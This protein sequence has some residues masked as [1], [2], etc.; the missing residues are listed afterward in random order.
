MEY[1]AQIEKTVDVLS[2]LLSKIPLN[3]DGDG[4]YWTSSLKVFISEL[5]NQQLSIE[6]D[7]LLKNVKED[8][9][10][11]LSTVSEIQHPCDKNTN[12]S[13]IL[14][15]S[16]DTLEDYPQM[17][18]PSKEKE[19]P[20]CTN[21][22]TNT[23]F[24]ETFAEVTMNPEINSDLIFIQENEL[25]QTKTVK[26]KYKRKIQVYHPKFVAELLSQVKSVECEKEEVDQKDIQLKSQKL[27]VKSFK[28]HCCLCKSNFETEEDL[29]NH[30][31]KLHCINETF[32]CDNCNFT[33]ATKKFLIEHCADQHKE[34]KVYKR[35]QIVKGG[36]VGYINRTLKYCRH[37]DQIFSRAVHLRKHLYE[38]H[39][40]TV[41]RN[42]CLMCLR[43]FDKEKSAMHHMDRTHI[44]LKIKCPFLSICDEIFNTD[45]EYQ[46]HFSLKHQKAD[47][48]TCHICGQVFRSNQRA[49][50]NRHVETHSMDGK[51]K[52][53]FQCEQCPKAFFFETD[54]KAHLTHTTH[55]GKVYPCTICDYK[56][57]KE[58]SL[59]AHLVQ[60]HSS[61]RPFECEICGKGF[62]NIRYFHK[63]QAVHETVRKYECY[64]C[65]KKFK[66]S[67]HLGVHV[68]IHRQEYSAQCEYC[69]AKF[70][71][72]QN[73]KP[74][75]KKHHPEMIM[76][77]QK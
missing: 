41:P 71:Q 48:Y 7:E 42:K 59:K 57:N 51:Q 5:Q 14:D 40:V 37:C 8:D 75:M 65:S 2:F 20:D 13:A 72:R 26:R 58:C 12:L 45:E 6:D 21:D 24:N 29:R 63:H 66:T 50:F 36:D 19:S 53:S 10:T 18:I 23:S 9:K 64:V 1:V 34:S 46:N 38:L 70:V 52:P 25:N 17:M 15:E 39:S 61:V 44:G 28:F 11:T 54:F 47:K 74:H 16:L 68:K 76:I 69:D 77:E 27:L 62:S 22:E 3:Y 30:D 67:K 56:A 49:G 73:I 33:S 60:R 35:R 32:K 4:S 43:E 55:S 31:L